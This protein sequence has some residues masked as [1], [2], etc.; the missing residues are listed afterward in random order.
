MAGDDVSLYLVRHGQT[1]GNLRN[2]FIGA[3]D[4]PLDDMGIRQASLLAERFRDI[5]LDAVVSSPLIRA[6]RTADVVAE[7]CGL[8][9]EVH[10]GLAEVDFGDAEGLTIDEVRERFSELYRLHAEP[11]SGGVH[12]PGGESRRA[13]CQRVVASVGEICESHR[14]R[15]VAVVCHGGVIGAF[16]SHVDGGLVNDWRKYSV[17][18]CSITHVVMTGVS[19][20]IVCRDDY[21]HLVDVQRD[22][23]ALE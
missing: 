2:L 1:E 9:V 20:S 8:A 11:Q 21:A 15:D 3:T 6:V 18:N 17:H 14:G 7:V 12:W 19:A 22:L 4:I 13:F 10:P 5:H 16:L 23:F